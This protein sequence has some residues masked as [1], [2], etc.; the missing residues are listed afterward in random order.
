MAKPIKCFGRDKNKNPITNPYI[1]LEKLTISFDRNE[2]KF[3][4]CCPEKYFSDYMNSVRGI[5]DWMDVELTQDENEGLFTIRINK[6][7][8]HELS[9]A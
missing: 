4:I 9:A 8:Q 5:S 2:K 1:V 6:P 7:A 3:S